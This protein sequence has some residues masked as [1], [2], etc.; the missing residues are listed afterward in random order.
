MPR[1]DAS[2][3]EKLLLHHSVRGL[4]NSHSRETRLC[5]DFT[6]LDD[7]V[8]KAR[9]IAVVDGCSTAQEPFI[10]YA[11]QFAGEQS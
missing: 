7:A 9:L 3:A 2:S 10:C 11:H 5:N 6:T 1:L 4:P 8:R